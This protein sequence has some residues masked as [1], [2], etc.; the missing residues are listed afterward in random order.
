[1]YMGMYFWQV[2]DKVA[3]HHALLGGKTQDLL[4][5]LFDKPSGLMDLFYI[6]TSEGFALF[7]V[8]NGRLE[9]KRPRAAWAQF[10]RRRLR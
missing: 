5:K 10:T 6:M 8:N 2:V 4:E 1:M 3:S 7:E 9:R